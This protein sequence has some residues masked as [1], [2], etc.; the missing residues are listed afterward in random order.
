[1]VSSGPDAVLLALRREGFVLAAAG[2]GG[3]TLRVAPAARLT[4]QHRIA[5][6][7]QKGA[8]LG[9]LRRE[10]DESAA[11]RRAPHDSR[12]DL[13]ACQHDA[14]WWSVLL[15]LAH[16][17]HGVDDPRGVYGALHGSRCL[18]AG[19]A[20]TSGGALRI[21]PGAI[22]PAEWRDLRG[23]WLVPHRTAITELLV[24]VAAA[25]Q[26]L[27]EEFDDDASALAEVRRVWA[28]ARVLTPA[29]VAAI[30]TLPLVDWRRLPRAL[31]AHTP[32]GE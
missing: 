11:R 29:E 10:A 31:H 15:A 16:E 1:M 22:P 26:L 8:I 12:P 20:R 9:L 5:L 24:A 30:D 14:V 17:V 21:V 3:T 2:D 4:P 28:R 18:G 23:K 25:E 32:T 7:T 19:L 27:L 6:R 13:E